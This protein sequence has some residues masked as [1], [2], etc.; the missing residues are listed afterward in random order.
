[1]RVTTYVIIAVFSI[2][3]LFVQVSFSRGSIK[4]CISQLSF[5]DQAIL[6][7][8]L[9]DKKSGNFEGKCL[10]LISEEA[11]NT[12]KKCSLSNSQR[13]TTLLKECAA[14]L[15]FNESSS[16]RGC[17]LNPNMYQNGESKSQ[18]IDKCIEQLPDSSK[19]ELID[20]LRHSRVD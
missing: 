1:M 4:S 18:V 16:L 5:Q 3:S 9:I 7:Q 10:D 8:C 2:S 14:E 11:N 6:K 17:I 20:C 12:L 15:P 13:K 19:E